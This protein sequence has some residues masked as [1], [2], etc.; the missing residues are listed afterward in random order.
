MVGHL[1]PR[2]FELAQKILDPDVKL[3]ERL[4][5]GW[6]DVN[7]R[8][9]T[10]SACV[11]PTRSS[12]SEASEPQRY[13]RVDHTR[14]QRAAQRIRELQDCIPFGLPTLS[15]HSSDRSAKFPFETI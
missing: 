12:S 4:V 7:P 14:V 2:C 15:V 1:A 13:H 8:P 5:P 11:S 9:V 10:R 3:I 6:H